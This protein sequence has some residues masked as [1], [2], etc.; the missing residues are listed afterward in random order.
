MKIDIDLKEIIQE[1]DIRKVGNNSVCI[2]GKHYSLIE[3]V[4][5]IDEVADL[6]TTLCAFL[7]EMVRNGK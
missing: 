6:Q 4:E 3:L 2:D 5:L 1:L 7:P